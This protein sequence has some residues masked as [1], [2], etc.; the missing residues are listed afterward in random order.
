MIRFPWSTNPAAQAN[1]ARLRPERTGDDQALEQRYPRGKPIGT[2]GGPKRAFRV[3]GRE[4][5]ILRIAKT[6]RGG[7]FA[8]EWEALASLEAIGVPVVGRIERGTYFDPALA[9]EPLEADVLEAFVLGS[10]DPGFRDT[11]VRLLNARSLD[12]LDLIEGQLRRHRVVVQDLQFLVGA[13]GRLV[14]CDPTSLTWVSPENTG[15]VGTGRPA[16]QERLDAMRGLI[17]EALDRR[18]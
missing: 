8:S 11:A 1:A 5:V 9:P 3:A 7:G 6:T 12:D 16:F 10:K 2:T 14:V 18:R 13:D 15:F 17:L 4:D